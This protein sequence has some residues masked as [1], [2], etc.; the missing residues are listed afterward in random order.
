VP[1]G[2]FEIVQIW[3]RCRP[4]GMGGAPLMPEPGG[5]LDQG[6]WLMAAFDIMNA[7]AALIEQ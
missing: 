3:L 4:S 5:V 2:Y 7:E 6:C 1:G